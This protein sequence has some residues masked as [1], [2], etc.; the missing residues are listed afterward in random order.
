MCRRS[1]KS[2]RD[3]VTRHGVARAEIEVFEAWFGDR[4]DELFST[5]R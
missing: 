3:R 5:G 2:L 4:F 1:C